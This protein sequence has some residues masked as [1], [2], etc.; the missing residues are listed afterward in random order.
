MN[1]RK[2]E[3]ITS[4][5]AYEQINDAFESLV[6]F[7]SRIYDLLYHELYIFEKEGNRNTEYFDECLKR[8]KVYHKKIKRITDVIGTVN[9]KDFEAYVETAAYGLDT[10]P[11]KKEIIVERIGT[12]FQYNSEDNY[13]IYDEDE[14]E[15][16][17]A[18]NLADERFDEHILNL[19]IDFIIY[20]ST[21]TDRYPRLLKHKYEL[22]MLYPEIEKELLYAGYDPE[23][24]LN[25]SDAAR[26]QLMK[27]DLTDY[28]NEVFEAYFECITST[29]DSLVS[30]TEKADF[31]EDKVR[32]MLDFISFTAKKLFIEDLRRLIEINEPKLQ[33][34]NTCLLYED[35]SVFETIMDILEGNLRKKELEEEIERIAE[36]NKKANKNNESLEETNDE[37]NT[38]TFINGEKMGI[39][40][41]LVKQVIT[42]SQIMISLYGL[43]IRGENNTPEYDSFINKLRSSVEKEKALASQIHFNDFERDMAVEL[44]EQ[45]LMLF[46]EINP[47]NTLEELDCLGP[48]NLII[49]YDDYIKSRIAD[50]IPN[51][52]LKSN[53]FYKSK[54]IPEYIIS[55]QQ[56]ETLKALETI[57]PTASNRVTLI[58]AKYEIILASVRIMD[59]FLE[60]NGKIS[61]IRLL[62]DALSA[63]LLGIDIDEYEFDKSEC[64]TRLAIEYF[65]NIGA[66][67]ENLTPLEEAREEIA[68]LFTSL[69]IDKLLPEH[70]KFLWDEEYLEFSDA[71]SVLKLEKR[72]YDTW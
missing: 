31:D 22:G 66:P 11:G 35:V 30:L 63:Y 21:L 26:A 1:D 49:G 41:D 42:T 17:D 71:T 38:A 52:Y 6:D 64:L 58:V 3:Y 2:N 46:S 23:N 24:L 16:I 18:S 5:E 36:S 47:T 50:L 56:L 60:Y 61:E 13:P 12:M 55:T 59:A 68:N 39:L 57:I 51:L 62:D 33:S 40:F 69:S 8:L 67:T 54:E 7:F 44:V 53:S 10:M 72:Y 25:T 29:I 20:S 34:D 48:S 19:F 70:I 27:M 15:M 43:E 65:N 9:Y 28:E 14:E 4:M 45:N 37:L 32:N